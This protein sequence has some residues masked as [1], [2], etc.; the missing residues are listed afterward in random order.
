MIIQ[1]WQWHKDGFEDGL[2]DFFIDRLRGQNIGLL[3]I[4]ERVESF[5]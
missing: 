2:V 5:V 3:N 1:K 4:G